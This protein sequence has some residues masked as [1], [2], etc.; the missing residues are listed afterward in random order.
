MEVVADASVIVKWFIEEQDSDKALILRDRHISR[1]ITISLPGLAPYE[2]LNALKWSRV[3]DEGELKQIG[4][5]LNKY[6]FK[7]YPLIGELK[8]KTIEIAMRFDTTIYDASYVAL[9]SHLDTTLYTADQEL[10][11]KIS[12]P[13]I[14]P[15]SELK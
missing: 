10:I 14:I 6:G 12:F 1:E 2:I 5:S 3:Y 13:W 4:G 11:R 9:A 8:R 7:T 15:I